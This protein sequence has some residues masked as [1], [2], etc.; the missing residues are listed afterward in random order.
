MTNVTRTSASHYEVQKTRRAQFIEDWRNNHRT[1]IHLEDVEMYQTSRRLRTGV[2]LGKD[3]G[4]PVR[5]VDAAAHEIAPG[6]VSTI[7]RH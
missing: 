5:T 3:G 1:V 6:T 7:H 4:N 2:Y